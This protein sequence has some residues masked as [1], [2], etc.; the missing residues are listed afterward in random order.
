[1]KPSLFS[2][3]KYTCISSDIYYTYEQA[4]FC[5][6]L[7]TWTLNNLQWSVYPL[8]IFMSSY[9][10]CGV[11]PITSSLD[12]ENLLWDKRKTKLFPVKK[13]YLTLVW[14]Q[15]VTLEKKITLTNYYENCLE[16]LDVFRY[17][18]ERTGVWI[19]FKE[20]L[21]SDLFE[22]AD[23]TC[24][25]A[26]PAHEVTVITTVTLVITGHSRNRGYPRRYQMKL[27]TLYA[28]RLLPGRLNDPGVGEDHNG[29]GEYKANYEKKYSMAAIT[30]PRDAT[31]S[32]ALRSKLIETPA[33]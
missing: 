16:R 24:V 4:K 20:W 26:V 13:A 8:L 12:P 29:E 10:K 15:A 18:F 31:Y 3:F 19:H 22:G 25:F 9:W 17:H 2:S 7:L 30:A 1:M 11:K 21:C 14:N 23:H 27:N 33:K 28:T 32:N 5:M 6:D